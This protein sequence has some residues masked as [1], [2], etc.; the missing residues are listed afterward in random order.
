[1]AGIDAEA[2]FAE[3]EPAITALRDLVRFEDFNENAPAL[4]PA[5]AAEKI[6]ALEAAFAPLGDA[7]NPMALAE[8]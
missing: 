3:L 6:A 7:L 8:V 5:E 4:T 1:M 2:I